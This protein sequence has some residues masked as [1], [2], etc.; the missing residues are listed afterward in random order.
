MDRNHLKTWLGDNLCKRSLRELQN[1]DGGKQIP[2]IEEGEKVKTG[3]ELRCS[4]RKKERRV[5]ALNLLKGGGT[6]LQTR[7]RRHKLEMGVTEHRG[8]QGP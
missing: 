7:G 5:G 3:A 1:A 4:V 8:Q 2:S 6:V